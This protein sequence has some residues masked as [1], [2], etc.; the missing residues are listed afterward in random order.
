M[1]KREATL[2]TAGAICEAI[3]DDLR[4]GEKVAG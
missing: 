2:L 3:I 4:P 1:L